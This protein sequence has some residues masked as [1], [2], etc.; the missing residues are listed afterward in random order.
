MERITD[1]K[2]IQSLLNGLLQHFAEVC[3]RHGLRY[4]LSNGTLLGAEKY[5][6]FIPWDDDVDV[7]MPREDYDKLMH[8][9]EIHT[10]RYQLRS[11]ETC[12][13]W[14]LPFAKL[15]DATTVCYETT[16]DFGCELGLC[17]DIF[18]LDHWSD[19]RTVA[20]MEAVCGGLLRRFT[21]ASLEKTFFSP[22]TGW[23]RAILY[24]IWRFSRLLGDRFFRQ[25]ILRMTKKHAS[26]PTKHVGCIAWAAYGKREVIPAEAFSRQSM[27]PFEGREYPVFG[28]YRDY[29]HRMYGAYEEDPP[30]DRQKTHHTFEIYR[31][32]DE[33]ENQHD[34]CCLYK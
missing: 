3:E 26:T 5:S 23:K 28:G 19:N 15:T 24:G 13:T 21:S 20:T 10:E 9:Q 22:R 25:C 1:I 12:Q 17:M 7:L 32:I 30:A 18:P 4:Y 27:L 31:K 8:L 6:G 14:R 29:L 2:E 34:M 33:E 11:I 16:A